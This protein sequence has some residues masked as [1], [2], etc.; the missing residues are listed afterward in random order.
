MEALMALTWTTLIAGAFVAIG[1]PIIV[2]LLNRYKRNAGW[3]FF[4]AIIAF[5]L[6]GNVVERLTTGA[7]AIF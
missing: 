4:V 2:V 7:S 6:I 3:W 5:I 1:L